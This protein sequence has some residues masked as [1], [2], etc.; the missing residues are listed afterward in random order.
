MLGSI[1]A[2]A[3]WQSA[4]WVQEL[5]FVVSVDFAT[6]WHGNAAITA[7]VVTSASSAATAAAT[8]PAIAEIGMAAAM[9]PDKGSHA[10]IHT[11]ISLRK[12]FITIRQA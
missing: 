2:P 3:K 10:S 4:Q 1:M 6:L 7:A 11:N 12:K 5:L 8:F 9:T